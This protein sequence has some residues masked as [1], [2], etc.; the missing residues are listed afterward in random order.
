MEE[1]LM[2][3]NLPLKLLNRGKARDMYEIDDSRLII[4]TT[5][6]ISAFDVVMPKGVINKGKVLTQMSMFW[7][8]LLSEVSPNHLITSNIKDYP[9]KLWEYKDQLD[10]RSMM[11]QKLKM[12]PIESIVR[13]YLAGSGWKEYQENQTVCG[14]P[15]PAGLRE[16]D[17]LPNPI[18]TP[19]TK[20]GHGSHDENISPKQVPRILEAWLI[21]NGISDFDP[22]E[23][24]TLVEKKSIELYSY[25]ASFAATRGIIIA[26]T[27]FEFGLDEQNKLVVGDEVLTPDSSRFWDEEKYV[28]GGPQNSFDK[29]YL[30]DYLETTGWDK[31]SPPPALPDE[32]IDVTASKYLEAYH[33]ITGGDIII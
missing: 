20:A 21:V 29:Q 24:A 4:V 23:L 17:R 27:K 9:T 13:G 15:L 28:P 30:R 14:I 32:V 3:S 1:A 6:R 2:Q 7:F 12:L 26:D 11:V 19:S 25:A 8:N 33:R 18:F 31:T 22:V 16:S 5:D 10:G